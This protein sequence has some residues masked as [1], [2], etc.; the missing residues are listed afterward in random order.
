MNRKHMTATY[1]VIADG[2][3]NRYCFYCALSGAVLCTT[4]PVKAASPEE[5]LFLAWETEGRQHFNRCSK[6]GRWV[7]SVMFNADVLACVDCSPWESTPHY[8]SKCGAKVEGDGPFCVKC[9]AKL[10]YGEVH[11]F[12]SGSL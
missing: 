9:G 8:C 10:Q 7:S 2:G 5:E 4:K 12:G 11:A 3:G 1:R 6:C